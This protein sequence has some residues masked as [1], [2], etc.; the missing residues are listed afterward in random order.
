ME[1][2]QTLEHVLIR[3]GVALVLFS[4]W[5]WRVKMPT[6]F[7]AGLSRNMFQEFE[8][9]GF[10]PKIM[11]LVWVLKI[12]ISICFLCGHWIPFA[13]RPAAILLVILMFVAV[14]YHI[15]VDRTKPWKAGPAYVVLFFATY[16]AIM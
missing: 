4:V 13:I 14:L 2:W 1:A 11:Y 6:K 12:T 16:L 3:C 15:K 8:V 5:T 10:S 7:R 9:Y